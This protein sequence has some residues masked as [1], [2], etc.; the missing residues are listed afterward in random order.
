MLF[1]LVRFKQRKD[2]FQL[3]CQYIEASHDV[4]TNELKKIGKFELKSKSV[5]GG[6]VELIIELRSK[7]DDTSFVNKISNIEG[8]Q[9]STLLKYDGDYVS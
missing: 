7:N 1:L 3:V 4:V 9:N 5:S 6:V 8:V 2:P